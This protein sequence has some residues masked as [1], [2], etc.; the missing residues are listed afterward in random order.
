MSRENLANSLPISSGIGN[1]LQIFVENQGRIN[2]KIANDTKGIIGDVLYNNAPLANW[3][4]TGFPFEDARKLNL[5]AASE[6]HQRETENSLIIG[7]DGRISEP[8]IF[9]GTFALDEA[10]IFDTF[11]NTEGWGKVFK[12]VQLMD[13]TSLH[14]MRRR[15]KKKRD[16]GYK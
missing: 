14:A 3:T 15:E 7:D 2:F 13:L 9:D 6:P 11:I 5:F 8:A 4:I 10:Q 16:S 12:T 1:R